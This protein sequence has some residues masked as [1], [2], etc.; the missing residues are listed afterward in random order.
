MYSK[1]QD[2]SFIIAGFVARDA[3]MKTS[4]NGKTYTKWGVKVGEK[5]SQVQGERGEAIWTN[6]IA[7]HDMARYAG[8]IKKG[9]T[10]MVIGRIETSEYEGKTYKTLNAEYIS[11]MGKGTAQAQAT[12][13]AP[14]QTG[15]NVLAEYEE[16][17]GDGDLPF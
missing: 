14:Q 17:L 10:V 11:I 7:W 1:L 6:C 4:Q 12:T 16:I 9:D 3:E 8:Q 2:G 5:P 15:N 13:T